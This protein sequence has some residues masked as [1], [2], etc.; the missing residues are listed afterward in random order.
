MMAGVL[1]LGFM[2]Y[3]IPAAIWAGVLAISAIL[4]VSIKWVPRAKAI[5]ETQTVP[6]RGHGMA[7]VA[8]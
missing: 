8:S 1:I 5:K 4:G 7:T 3:V 6:M 2:G